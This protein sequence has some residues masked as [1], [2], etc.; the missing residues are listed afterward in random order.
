LNSIEKEITSNNTSINSCNHTISIL[1]TTNNKLRKELCGCNNDIGNLNEETDKLSN[2]NNEVN[3]ISNKRVELLEKKQLYDVA[4]TLLKDTGIKT[5]II[6]EYIPVIN[7]LINKYLN[8][9]DFY[10][11]FELDDTFQEIIRSRNRDIFSYNSFSE[12]EKQKITISIM[13]TWRH[14]AKMKNSVNTNLLIM[15]EIFDSS[16]DTDG[17]ELL[18][19]ILKELNKNLETNIFII[20]H[21]DL[22]NLDIFQE[23]IKIEKRNEFSVIT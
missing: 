5:A 12:G 2:L 19:N 10:A 23:S 16:L 20:S 17:V 13:L 1:T 18:S 8:S 6:H 14:I 22:S 15:D 3:D 9:M 4:F 7:K 11:Q 21:R